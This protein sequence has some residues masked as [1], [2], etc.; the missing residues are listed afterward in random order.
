MTWSRETTIW[1]DDCMTWEQRS[2]GKVASVRKELKALG[3]TS[4]REDGEVKDWCPTCS[5]K[6]KT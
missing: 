2:G 3:W 6:R 1:C 4:R 5:A